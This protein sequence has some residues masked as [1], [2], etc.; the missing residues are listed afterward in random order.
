MGINYKISFINGTEA[1]KACA[2]VN[3]CFDEF[4]APGYTK[5][6]RDEFK[7]FASP[8]Q[9]TERLAGGSFALSAEQDGEIVGFIEVK[10]Y[11]HISLLFVKKEFHRMGIAKKLL[12]SALEICRKNNQGLTK[13][14]VNS[15]PYAV[16]IY[17]KLGF[18]KTD[19]E[20]AANG[21]IFTPMSFELANKINSVEA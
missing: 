14:L 9:M 19:D 11:N 16:E 20:R 4:V 2:L 3:G 5:E 18:E 8:A 13:L 12:E 1:V 7:K 17:E 15:S 21:I 6:G 10:D